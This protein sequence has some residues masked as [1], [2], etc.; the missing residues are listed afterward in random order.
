MDNLGGAF[1]FRENQ[2]DCAASANFDGFLFPWDFILFPGTFAL[3]KI[4]FWKSSSAS[5]A[6]STPEVKSLCHIAT[7]YFPPA[8]SCGNTKGTDGL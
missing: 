7:T 3:K 8:A 2:I 4:L 1:L 5:V 6:Y